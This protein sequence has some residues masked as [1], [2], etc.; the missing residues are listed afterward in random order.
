MIIHCAILLSYFITLYS[1]MHAAGAWQ[2][3]FGRTGSR[4]TPRPA[5]SPPGCRARSPRGQSG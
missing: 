2:A 3:A 5:R 4:G 1:S